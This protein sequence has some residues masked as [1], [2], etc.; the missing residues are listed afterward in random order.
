MPACQSLSL[1]SLRVIATR[2]P[3]LMATCT[4]SPF[5]LSGLSGFTCPVG[6]VKRRRWKRRS[7]PVIS[8]YPRILGLALWGWPMK[9]I[10]DDLVPLASTAIVLPRAPYSPGLITIL[11]PG[12]AFRIALPIVRHGASLVPGFRFDPEVETNLVRTPARD[13][14]GAMSTTL[15]RA[16]PITVSALNSHEWE[17]LGEITLRGR[18]LLNARRG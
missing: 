15:A 6:P 12:R 17:R 1:T 16:A 8:K 10:G 7:W 2:S 3:P 11:M 9:V 13:A 14:A 4:C 5:G 18:L